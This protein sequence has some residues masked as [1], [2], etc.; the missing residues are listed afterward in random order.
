[1]APTRQPLSNT[2]NPEQTNDVELTLKKIFNDAQ[3]VAS[4]DKALNRIKALYKNVDFTQFERPFRDLIKRMLQSKQTIFFKTS[5]DFVCKFLQHVSKLS[6]EA[7]A[8]QKGALENAAPKG[9]DSRF[10]IATATATNKRGRGGR[11]KRA[12]GRRVAANQEDE[13]LG[14]L[15]S[16]TANESQDDESTTDD[17][18]TMM[19]VTTK[20]RRSCDTITTANNPQLLISNHDRLLS[21]CMD[22]ANHYMSVQDEETR[23]NA[24]FLVCKFISHVESLDEEICKALKQNLPQRIRD[25]K[26]MIRAQAVLASRIFQDHDMTKNGFLHHFQKDPELV[27]RKALLQ[28]MDTKVFGYDFLVHSTQDAHE[29]MR[30]SAFQRLGKID[31]NE[32][33][34]KQLHTVIHNGLMER[35]DS[36][37]FAFK[38]QNLNLWLPK[39]YD[40]LDLYKL[41]SKFDV[42][43]HHEDSVKLLELVFN[44]DLNK[45]ENNGTSTKLHHVVEAFRERWLNAE[46]TRLPT[47]SQIDDKVTLIWLTLANFCKKRQTDI[48]PVKVR[49]LGTDPNESIEKILDTQERE[50]DEEMMELYERLTPDL[51]NLVDFLSR[52]VQYA[53]EAI[54]SKE[55]E[56]AKLEYIYH[57]LIDYI[58]TFQVMDEAERKTVQETFDL[59]LRENLLTNYFSSFILPLINSLFKL[60]YSRSSNL[61]INY[62]SEMINNVRSHLEDLI[63]STQMP[64]MSLA[65]STIAGPNAQQTPKP[66]KKVKIDAT[67][68]VHREPEITSSELEYRVAEMRVDLE[69]LNDKL[70]ACVK[71]K[72]FDQAKL[73]NTQ[74]TDLK[75][76]LA[77]LHDRR[78]SIASDVSHMSMVLDDD[79]NVNNKISSTMIGDPAAVMDESSHSTQDKDEMK[80]VFKHHP[81]ELIKCFQMYFGCLQ[82]VKVAQV[83]QTMRNHLKNMTWES[84]DDSF[85]NEPRIRSL[86]IAS[87]GI[88]AL[89][90]KEF[91]ENATTNTLL[92]SACFESALEIKTAAF[93]SV[94]DILCHYDKIEMQFAQIESFMKRHLKMYG[95]YDPNAI[96]KNEYEFITALVEGTAKLLF[97]KKLYSPEIL[98]HLILWWYHP[99]TPSRLKQ[100]IGIFLPH[101]VEVMSKEKEGGKQNQ[102]SNQTNDDDANWLEELLMET[103]VTS[104]QLLHDYILGQGQAIMSSEDMMSLI[105]FLC[106][107][108]PYSYHANLVDRVD[109]KIDSLS[110]KNDPSVK[111]LMKY[112]KQAKN[113]LNPKTPP[114]KHNQTLCQPLVFPE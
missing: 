67:P 12:A 69:E 98:S 110:D 32:L 52:F 40:G 9:R 53:S 19:D 57:Q 17:E 8:K 75:S 82:C 23:R 68:I 97:M 99:R 95:L 102:N 61:M 85:K 4:T 11:T 41:L 37:S 26:P 74:I 22:V 101:F 5:C 48:K 78:C 43:N 66:N 28:I 76:K 2:T 54:R 56:P 45:L 107:L 114:R 31:P 25:K 79:Q 29:I 72:D 49:H 70:E 77:L 112:F 14:G 38:T 83:P 13:L 84:L 73:I 71:D 34:S 62:I 58:C 55:V 108:I 46:P 93:K 36:A 3:H 96:K 94:V 113:H 100:F 106:N 44:K 81:N 30:R 35:D 63:T 59:I 91:A 21:S 42:V 20:R 88:T 27:V 7:K 87:N 6:D 80:S 86:M 92:V 60:I 65:Y 18:L 15:L 33:N 24:V 64:R 16:Q 10:S 104:I 1:M 90:D 111:D 51:V 109:D 39:L 47:L 105:I 103:F 89:I 50:K